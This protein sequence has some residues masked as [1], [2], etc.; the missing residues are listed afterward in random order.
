MA[1][2][3]SLTPRRRPLRQR[4][5]RDIDVFMRIGD[6]Q[7]SFSTPDPRTVSG[8]ALGALPEPS[9]AYNTG[10]A[11]RG[12]P[13]DR[14]PRL[15]REPTSSAPIHPSGVRGLRFNDGHGVRV[16]QGEPLATNIHDLRYPTSRVEEIHETLHGVEVVDPYRWLEDSSS[17]ETRDW[18][19]AQDRLTRRALRALPFRDILREEFE[20]LSRQD[21]LPPHSVFPPRRLEGGSGSRYF[22]LR[23]PFRAQQPALYRQD[24]PRGRRRIV[25]D[26]QKGEPDG[27]T[28]VHQAIPSWDGLKV[29]YALSVD[30][31]DCTTL[32]VREVRSSRDFD[33]LSNIR[34]ANVAWR[35]DGSGFYYSNWP[36]P[37]VAEGRKPP[38]VFFHRLGSRE[39]SDLPIFGEELERNQGVS[40]LVLDPHDDH[41]VILVERLSASSDLYHLDLRN[42]RGVRPLVVGLGA[43][44]V[45]DGSLVVRGG[46]VIAATEHRAPR[47]RVVSIPIDD[48]SVDSWRELVPEADG[49]LEGLAIVGDRLVLR[50]LEGAS[51][52]LRVCNLDGSALREIPLPDAGTVFWPPG[53][54]GGDEAVYTFTSFRTPR[55]VYRCRLPA[56]S[57]AILDRNPT[58][59]PRS[60]L[61]AEQVRYRSKDGTEVSMFLVRRRGI[62]RD[63]HTPTLL[64][65]YGG[66]GVCWT[67]AFDYGVLPFLRD[68]GI[69]AVPN[70]RGGGEYGKAW[71]DGGKRERKQ[72]VFDDFAGAA[73]WIIREGY[74]DPAHLAMKGLSNGGLLVGALLTQR[75]DLFRAA[76]CG[77]PVLDMLRYHLFGGGPLWEPEYGSSDDPAGFQYLWKYSPYHRVREGVRYPAVLVATADT[78]TRVN[79][80]HARKMAARLQAASSSG[81]PI[82]LR[83]DHKAGHGFGKSRRQT[84]EELTDI[85]SFLYD[86]LGLSPGGQTPRRRRKGP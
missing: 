47:R 8:K 43:L 60:W 23:R 21:L 85:W 66:F 2:I 25:V 45:G 50:Y 67:P 22:L 64:E 37:A 59:S 73:E 34:Y 7:L 9:P 52:R 75:P 12:S 69:Y 1:P 83:T 57:P 77:V 5:Y 86:Q 27:T 68:G 74:S 13:P 62:G 49:V 4:R 3:I 72:N 11:G 19:R 33:S 29:L 10:S 51:S 26:P 17:R 36:E 46:R 55:T 84:V 41:L 38:Q 80:L 61:G 58:P 65:G 42:G 56:G 78:D 40:D 63:G 28:S 6:Y 81:L 14:S 32:T 48:P 54:A 31:S 53:E 24:G 18:V 76:V 82:L 15:A 79:P 39:A 35:H 30:G 71:H 70:L 44:F 20:S 16:G